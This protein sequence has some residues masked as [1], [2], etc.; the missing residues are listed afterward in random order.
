[1]LTRLLGLRV[2]FLLVMRLRGEG[3]GSERLCLHLHDFLT[4]DWS[5][6]ILLGLRTGIALAV[7]S[8]RLI[9]AVVAVVL[10]LLVAI[11][12]AWVVVAVILTVLF[13]AA[14][15]FFGS[16][17]KVVLSLA[18]AT[19]RVIV[20]LVR[21]AFALRALVAIAAV[22]DTSVVSLATLVALVTFVVHCNF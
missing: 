13:L 19:V 21:V 10:S 11:L 9:F 1:L 16:G 3:L 6:D 7:L 5:V 18:V 15:A 17:L 22:G 2:L 20:L 14:I 12:L 4:V 8:T